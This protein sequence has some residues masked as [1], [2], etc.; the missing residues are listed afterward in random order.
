[1]S[2]TMQS[3]STTAA[4][5]ASSSSSSSHKPS[6]KGVA[7][8]QS[9][10]KISSGSS[11]STSTN[12]KPLPSKAT[13]PI[14]GARGPI[15][16]KPSIRKAAP[17]NTATTSSPAA[18]AP[19]PQRPS[20]PEQK[21]PVD[22]MTMSAVVSPAPTP[23]GPIMSM[24]TKEWVIPPRPKPGRK[25][26]TDTPPTKRKAQN[27]AAQRA[28]RERRAARVGELEEQLDQQKA[29]N[30]QREATYKDTIRD[31]E[32]EVQSFRSRCLLLENMLEKERRERIQTET[33]LETLRRQADERPALRTVTLPE[34]S[35]T[36]L[37]NNGQQHPATQYRT[38]RQNSSSTTSRS[39]SNTLPPITNTAGG[40]GPQGYF[41]TETSLTCGNCEVSGRCACVEEVLNAGCGKC[42]S[43]GSCQCM[44]EAS[45]IMNRGADLKRSASPTGVPAIQKRPRSNPDD[46][47]SPVEVDFTNM[48]QRRQI[49]EV[50][51]PSH[52]EPSH[53]ISGPPS[54]DNP[55]LKDDCGF[56]KDGTYCVCAD[57]AMATPAMTPVDTLP[58]INSQTQT[59]PPSEADVVSQPLI[60]EM[61]AEGAVK[62]P[63]RTNAKKLVALAQTQAPAARGCGSGAPGTCDQ[64]RADPKSGL[65]CR[66]MAA[67]F[68][69][70]EGGAGGCCGG[71]GVDGGCCKNK[72]ASTPS[73]ALVKEKIT[74]PSL[75]SLGLS[76][77]EA[78]QTLASH[79]NFERA[80]DDIGSWLPKLKTTTGGSSRALVPA[81]GGRMGPIEVEAASIMSVLKDFDTLP[82]RRSEDGPRR[83][84]YNSHAPT[85]QAL[86]PSES[87]NQ[88]PLISQNEPRT[89]KRASSELRGPG[90]TT[91]ILSS[92][93][94]PSPTAPK[95]LLQDTSLYTNPHLTRENESTSL[96]ELA[97]LVRL[98]KFQERKRA[99]T[100]I[101]LQ[102]SLI[103][104]ALSARLTRCGET[105]NRN[106]AECF[107]KDDKDSF[108]ALFNAIHD[109]RKSCHEL[110][111]Y[112]LLE[113]DSEPLAPASSPPDTLDAHSDLQRDALK[114]S[115]PFF[116]DMAASS[117]DTFLDFI[118]QIRTNPDYLPTRI[119]A[120]SSSELNALFA[121]H[122]G[123]EPFDS[124][125]PFQGRSAGRSYNSSASRANANA[126]IERLLSFHR[127]D[128][129]SVLIH[130][131]FANS[132]GPESTEDRRRTEVWAA[133]LAKLISEPKS[134]GEHLVIS[135][136]NIWITMREWSGRSNMEWYLLKILEDGAFLLDR[137]EDQHGTRFNLSDWNQSDEAA[138]AEFYDRAVDELF[139]LADD[140]DATG[141]PEGLL[142]LGHAILQKLDGPFLENTTR[143]LVWRCLFFVFFMGVITH[144]ESYGMLA[145]YYITP[146]A[147]EKVLKKV[148]MKA[149]DY[150]SRMWTGKP[151]ST[152]V[153]QDI[154]PKIKGHVESII[155]RFQG[156][157]P[158]VPTAKLLP[159]RSIT[160]LRETAEVHPYLVISP[161]EL[162]TL[163]N[164]LFPDRRPQSS[165]SMRSGPTPLS[166]M[167]SSSHPISI[168]G[169]SNDFETASIIST[170]ASSVP[171]DTPMMRDSM[172]EDLES[173]SPQRYS[174]ITVD[175]EAERK[176]RK[177]EDDGHRL[178]IALHEMSQSLGFDTVHGSSHPCA[179]RWAVLFISP[180]GRKLS[181]HMTYDP[182]DD[183]EEDDHSSSS[184]TDEDS[185]DDSAQLDKDYHQLRDSIL[186]L[187]EDYE[188]P[189]SLEP[190][191]ES[192]HL[193]NRASRLR[194][195]KSKNK[196]ITPERS[197]P[198]RNPYRRDLPEESPTRGAGTGA[199]YAGEAKVAGDEA[200]PVLVTMLK[201]AAAQSKAHADFV[202]SHMYWKTLV[203]LNALQSSSLR[204]DGFSVLINIFSRGPRDSIRRSASAVEE[205]EAWLVWLKQ[206]QERHDGSIERMMSRARAMRDKMW[207]VTEVRN[208]RE[209]AHSRDICQ[210]LRTMGMP[211]RW[212]SF[213]RTRANLARGPGTSYLYRT[214][215]QIMDLLA[216]GEEQGGPNKLSDDQAEMTSTWLKECDVEN[217][218]RGEE[219]I[220]RFCCEVD[221]C[222]SKLVAETISEAPALWSSDL[223]KRDKLV[224]DRLRAAERDM[225]SDDA[226]S[227]ASDSDR[228]ASGMSSRPSPMPRDPR[229]GL[230]HHDYFDRTSPT[231]GL[232]FGTFWSPFHNNA[233]PGHLS[234]AY[235]PASSVTNLST[236]QGSSQHWPPASSFSRFPGRPGTA[237]S[238]TETIHQRR[239]DNRMT[240]FLAE[241][242]KSLTSLLLS[243]LGTQVFSRG[244]ET[245]AWFRGLGQECIDRK[246]A[247][248]RRAKQKRRDR[249]MR[250]SGRPRVIE[251]KKS[252]GNLRGAGDGLVE[253]VEAPAQSPS[254]SNAT[255]TMTSMPIS[256]LPPKR[257]EFP[258]RKAYSRLL[259]MFTVHPSPFAK[260]M[261]LKELEDLILASIS[262]SGSKRSRRNRSDAGS[263]VIT[264]E[265]TSERRSPAFDSII[266]NVKERRSLAMQQSMQFP[267]S[268][269]RRQDSSDVQSI[270]S[271][272]TNHT[273]AVVNELQSLFRDASIRPS[274]LFRDLQLIAAF[275]PLSILDRPDLGKAF[276]NAGLAALQLKAEVCRTMVEMAD[277]VV[278]ARTQTRT[279]NATGDLANVPDVPVSSTGTPP[280]PSMSYRLEDA[281][282]MWAITAK[283][284]SAT[285]QR[286]LALFYLSNPEAVGRTT[287]PLSKPREV[288]K[289]AVME[290]YGRGKSTGSS[291]P[292]LGVSGNA[293][294]ATGARVSGPGAASS[295][296]GVT[297]SEAKEG[298]V[299]NDP[300]LMCVAV[301]WMDA[302][303]RGGDEL[304][305][306]FLRQNDSWG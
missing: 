212:S 273:D 230:S 58:P 126:D 244:S 127:H 121:S 135:V 113:P 214:E 255:P 125:L 146:Y 148:A 201:A 276:W 260:L 240:K 103:S 299:R 107:R 295:G 166:G 253:Q 231:H 40:V 245:D 191:S 128:P 47:D 300:G 205:Y 162:L 74:L 70:G 217:F 169:S 257:D 41:D 62:L 220:H 118:T 279:A 99:S 110:R 177:Y 297:G 271:S 119:C 96:E 234:R 30:D 112:A 32:L 98:S 42:G 179:E 269:Y 263:S 246:L 283:E 59:P 11:A 207:Y 183:G 256:S 215:S 4:P 140:E 45:T 61:T 261:A 23:E 138:A 223:Y 115:P 64:C 72:P 31:L 228:F 285:A 278:A 281:G 156:T 6:T 131:C 242:K 178:R 202:S 187:V 188:I 291:A 144:P 225:L 288:F 102:R 71:K 251:K 120:L 89:S 227:V 298:D 16:L 85:N 78:Y 304:A 65:F 236:F 238:S 15:A 194:K 67:N 129:L 226:A 158:R 92:T 145:D 1:M 87:R 284:G 173:L 222:V 305:T 277:E 171:L 176:A 28:F 22:F 302:A 198:N 12:K 161:T 211:R 210:A 292:G 105:A 272:Y 247:L 44:D 95:P 232:D 19:A 134:S 43:G 157:R 79:R 266:E 97:H 57:T 254:S 293:A 218:C 237:A 301:H 84:P 51:Q 206:S 154:P 75:P 160:S 101:R 123:L 68:G 195:Y 262:A 83:S 259:S 190:E 174:P 54:L 303:M 155:A 9:S 280:P 124:V 81:K 294:S 213:Q 203:Q 141:I 108:I 159:A 91:P 10:V 90:E 35:Q 167:S 14:T 164:A 189:Q 153:P 109:V 122:K 133:T 235:S 17:Q 306:S 2:P 267:N 142:E 139:E 196:I 147:R 286:E 52:F 282:K 248:D 49:I 27:R 76:C 200:D 21:P 93:G 289:Q 180:D 116:N 29:E 221:K 152:S 270:L 175:Q 241:L 224:F 130:T 252:F 26:A 150:V 24:T 50:S 63:K 258:F 184:D 38:S 229:G 168:T 73:S 264:D 55:F 239:A 172:K 36:S 204:Q 163:V 233:S 8:T 197:R 94:A 18:V 34:P 7:A 290:K 53:P 132:A 243:D 182:E 143:W 185:D 208:S 25:P 186:K 104:T 136:L 274:S 199:G 82:I 149:H 170:S 13:A 268:A 114:L 106:L 111:R 39:G 296:P 20:P 86:N 181:T 165:A 216:A 275:V 117:R 77:A 193:S 3:G 69:K 33:T 56:C 209:Y 88:R 60:M 265:E 151:S 80:A 219:R 37:H 249:G 100:R 192:A 287:L 137:A 46:A 250:S 66:L 5:P 48:F